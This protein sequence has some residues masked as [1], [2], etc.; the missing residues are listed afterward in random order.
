V[1]SGLSSRGQ[2]LERPRGDLD[3]LQVDHYP[4]GSGITL[5]SLMTVIGGW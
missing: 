1:N 4:L 3:A 2:P 5:P